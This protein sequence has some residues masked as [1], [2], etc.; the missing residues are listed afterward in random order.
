MTL[1]HIAKSRRG[2]PRL[3]LAALALAIGCDTNKLVEVEDPAA[4]RPEEVFNA[5]AVPALVTGAFRQFHGAYS[6]LGGDAFLSASAVITDETYYGDTFTT[7]EAADKRNLQPV[8][9]GNISDAAFN[10]LMQ[11]RFNARRAFAVVEQ[12]ESDAAVAASADQYRANLRSIE[13]YAYVTLSEGWCSAVPFSNLPTTGPIDPATIEYGES[14]TTRQM[15][16][17]AVA[18]FNEALSFDAT[19][20]LAMMGKGRALLNNGQ[21]GAAAAAVAAVPTDYVFL[22]EHSVNSANENN[23]AT[24]LQQNGRYGVANLEGGLSPTGT[25]LRSDL[26]TH[27]LT[28]PSAEGLPFRALRDPRLPW[29][30][31]PDNNG[32][33]FSSSIFCWWNYNYFALDADVPLTSGVE[34]RLIEAEAALQAGDTALIMTRLNGL[35]ASAATLLPRLYPGQ[36]QVFFN[37]GGGVSL[38]PLTD[39]GVGLLTAAERFEARRAL[40]FRERALWLYHTGH[41]QGDLRRLVRNYGF[42]SSQVFPSGPHFRGGNYGADVAY[43]VPFNEQNNPNYDPADCVNS[44]A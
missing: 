16:D 13:G 2:T 18:R 11:A 10:R 21:F 26:N 23:P 14:L 5:A 37:A 43:P 9:L 32:R 15:N 27:P 35:R 41:R 20:R 30:A 36:K 25:A 44:Q 28:A 29:Q 38:D 34:A 39:P 24:A 7:R 17:T 22:L 3:A 42:T 4:L 8:V 19:Y 6:G 40:L 33:C 1:T 12:F 31:R